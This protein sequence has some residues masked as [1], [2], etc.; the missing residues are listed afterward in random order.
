MNGRSIILVQGVLFLAQGLLV[1][2]EQPFES[3][4]K[5]PVPEGDPDKICANS[6]VM[7]C[8]HEL[9]KQTAI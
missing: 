7:F 5:L 9:K 3:N 6:R 4:R 1:H 8:T 2:A